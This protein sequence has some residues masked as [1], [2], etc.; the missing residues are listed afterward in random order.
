[1][2]LEALKRGSDAGSGGL[3]GVDLPAAIKQQTAVLK[4]TLSS[5]G[6]Q[7]SVTAVKTD[8]VWPTLTDDRSDTHDVSQYYEEFEDVCAL[9]NNCE[10]MSFREQLLTLRRRCAGAGSRWKSVEV[11]SVHF[12]AK[13]TSVDS[14]GLKACR[15]KHL[16]GSGTLEETL[17]VVS[18]GTEGD[19]VSV[20]A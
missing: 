2:E 1:M 15:A 12:Q 10:G 9:A 3:A 11:L 8:L 4:D 6:N 16:D 19:S 18:S 20:R 17:R 14:D 13:R 5:W 7:S